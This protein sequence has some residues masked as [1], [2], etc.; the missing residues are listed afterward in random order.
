M[1]L[2]EEQYRALLKSRQF[3]TSLL[4][5]STR[6]KT[7]L[8]LKNGAYSCL[9]HFPMLDEKGKPIFSSDPFCDA[10]DEA[11][12]VSLAG[13]SAEPQKEKKRTTV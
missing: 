7:I 1:S 13:T 6:P 4:S 9:R 3:L 8:E 5:S 12:G 11:K 2:R 10:A